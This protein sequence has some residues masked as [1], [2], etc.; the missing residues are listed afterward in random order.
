MTALYEDDAFIAFCRGTLRIGGPDGTLRMADALPPG[1]KVL[2]AGCGIGTSVA[3][4]NKHDFDAY[5][6]DTSK[7]LVQLADDPRVRLCDAYALEGKYDALLYECSF[8]ILTNKPAALK[9]A[10]DALTHGGLLLMSDM[11]LRESE[12]SASGSP[13]ISGALS[14]PAL[15]E[16]VQQGGFS[17]LWF[18][19]ATDALHSFI[20][21]LIMEFG[22]ADEFLRTVA[23][24]CGVCAGAKLGYFYSVWRRDG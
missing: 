22:S 23:G 16:L 17:L 4:L 20:A 11:Y 8:S 19:D 14:K 5:G 15:F 6:I 7:K 10:Y 1:A 9:C 13:C 18:S 3:L 21:A 2:D 12:H 24:G